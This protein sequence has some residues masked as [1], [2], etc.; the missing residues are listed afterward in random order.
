MDG[1]FKTGPSRFVSEYLSLC[2]VSI[3][4]DTLDVIADDRLQTECH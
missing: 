2:G 1:D 4:S 3:E